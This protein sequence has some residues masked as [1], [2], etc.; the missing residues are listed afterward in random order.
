MKDNANSYYNL[1]RKSFPNFFVYRNF[2]RYY[3][4]TG[5]LNQNAICS[6]KV[7]NINSSKFWKRVWEKFCKL[8]LKQFE[9]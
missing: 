3:I 9:K 4:Y 6:T 1:C 8:T 7:E 2:E 5:I